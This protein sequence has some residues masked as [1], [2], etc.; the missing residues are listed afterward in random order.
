MATL[1]DALSQASSARLVVGAVEV[2][3]SQ[4]VDG[5]CALSVRVNAQPL[6]PLRRFA[7]LS[8]LLDYLSSGAVPSVRG[9]ERDWMLRGT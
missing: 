8:E 9:G 6:P 7:S 2:V 4:D 5:E 3:V 1:E